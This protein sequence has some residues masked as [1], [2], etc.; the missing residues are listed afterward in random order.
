TSYVVE[1]APEHVF[2]WAVEGPDNP[3]ATWRFR[4]EPEDGG[5][6]LPQS[7]RLGPARS[8]LPRAIGEAPDKEQKIV[9]VRLRGFGSGT[10]ASLEQAKE[11]AES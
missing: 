6:L 2:A 9:F 3:A 1:Y 4:P 10:T 7:A 8:G 11:P 5:T